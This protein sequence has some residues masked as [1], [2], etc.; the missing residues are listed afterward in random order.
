MMRRFLGDRRG[1]VMTLFALSAMVLSVLTAIVM[2]QVTFYLEKRRLQA[3]VDMAAL[4]MMASGNVGKE[5]ATLLI[6]EQTGRTDVEAEVTWG[7]YTPDASLAAA[8]RFKPNVTPHN[9][10]QVD[11]VLPGERVMMASLVPG[12]VEIRASARAARRQTVSLVIGSRLVRVEGGLSAALLDAVLGYKGKLTVMDYNS[13]ASAQVDAAQFLQAL[14][15]SAKIDAVSFNDVLTAPVSVGEIADAMADVTSDGKIVALLNK[16]S[17]PGG[18]KKLRLGA[19]IDPGS[20][21]GLP[22]DALTTGKSFPVSVGEILAGSAA[23]SDGDSQIAL[24]LG[25]VLGDNSIANVTLDVGEK[26]QVLQYASRAPKGA[27]AS[28]SQFKLNVGALGKAP[29][30]VLAVDVQLASAAVTVDEIRCQADGKAQVKLKAQTEAAKVGVK[31]LLLPKINLALGS[32]ETKTLTFTPADIAAQTY[33]P[34]RSGL[35]LQVGGLSLTQLLLIKPVDTLLEQL[36]LHV[37]EAD[38]KVTAADCGAAG[39]V[40]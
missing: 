18:L 39:L 15:L 9:A 26:P 38:V 1:S 35:G 21:G 40:H 36:G 10:I 31:A 30:S 28:T 7:S 34:V 11:A 25:A 37:A 14:A 5:R 27:K 13:L 32:G 20:I 22:L 19:F 6:A 23:L 24:N 2:T 12:D 29:A 8:N 17:P 16:A 33:K 4:I 3:A